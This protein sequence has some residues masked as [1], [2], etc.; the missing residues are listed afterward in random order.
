MVV[1]IN[2]DIF[3]EEPSWNEVLNSVNL[4][5]PLSEDAGITLYSTGGG[6]I[7]MAHMGKLLSM[8][9]SMKYCGTLKDGKVT[10]S[11]SEYEELAEF[12]DGIE[13]LDVFALKNFVRKTC[14]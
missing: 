12:N 13:E 2:G 11:M 3:A 5:P 10:S 6:S 9:S 1:V 4:S 14:L 7:A 8:E